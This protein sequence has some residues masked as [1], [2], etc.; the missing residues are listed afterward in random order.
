MEDEIKEWKVIEH[1][2]FEDQSS[3]LDDIENFNQ[4]EIII[5]RSSFHDENLSESEVMRREEDQFT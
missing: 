4:E 1:L 2:D 5:G 3:P